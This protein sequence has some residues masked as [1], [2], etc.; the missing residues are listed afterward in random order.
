MSLKKQI[1]IATS[2][3]LMISLLLSV[4]APAVFAIQGIAQAEERIQQRWQDILGMD[5]TEDRETVSHNADITAFEMPPDTSDTEPDMFLDTEYQTTRFIIVYENNNARQRGRSRLGGRGNRRLQILNSNRADLLIYDEELDIEQVQSDLAMDGV[6]FALIQPDF[7]LYMSSLEPGIPNLGSAPD[8]TEFYKNVADAHTASQGEG[9]LIA[10][11]D[12]G[13]E[14]THTAL[15]GRLDPNAWDFVNK[16][17]SV[18]DTDWAYEQGHGTHLAGI[19]VGGNGVEGIASQ[20]TLLPLKVFQ[21]GVAYTSDIIEAI[22]Y[23]EQKGASIANCSWGSRFYNPALKEAMTGSSMLFVTAAG[24]AAMNIDR[25]PVYPAAFD[26]PNVISV[27]AIDA[28]NK[29]SRFSNFG[30]ETIDI[31]APGR[32]VYSAWTGGRFVNNSGTSQAAAIISGQAALI[33][34]QDGDLS[35][36]QLRSRIISSGD[37]ITGLQDKVKDGRRVN[38]AAALSDNPVNTTVLDIPDEP[39]PDWEP[40]EVPDEDGYEEF[41]AQDLITRRASMPTARYGLQ[42]VVLNGEIW[43]I[44]GQTGNSNNNFLNKVEIYNPK[45][46]TWR[47]GPPMTT[48]R[49]YFGAVVVDGGIYVF[50][51][52]NSTSGNALNTVEFFNPATNQWITRTAMPA[53]RDSHTATYYNG[54]IYIIGGKTGVN[55]GFQNTVFRYNVAANTWTT[56]SVAAIRTTRAGHI[57]VELEGKLYIDG[58]YN[59]SNVSRYIDTSEFIDLTKPTLISEN[60]GHNRINSIRAATVSVGNQVYVAGG[61]VL[62]TSQFR[63]SVRRFV[64]FDENSYLQTVWSMSG[65]R[66]GLGAV[67]LDGNIY[68]IGGFYDNS[69]NPYD[70]VECIE[71]GQREKSPLPIQ[72]SDCLTVELDGQL[73]LA[74]GSQDGVYQEKMYRYNT[75]DNEWSEALDVPL[76]VDSR[77]VIASAY[78]K[79]YLFGGYTTEARD[80]PSK[81]IW[82]YDPQT[83]IWTPKRE[84]PSFSESRRAIFYEGIIYLVGGTASSS[85]DIYDPLAADP[86]RGWQA[87]KPVAGGAGVYNLFNINSSLVATKGSSVLTYQPATDTWESTTGPKV[88]SG[89]N[90]SQVYGDIF[91]IEQGSV[92][93]YLYSSNTAYTY[94]SFID[95][96]IHGT[97]TVDNKI[98]I[99]A[100]DSSSASILLEYTPPVNTWNN[101]TPTLPVFS[102]FSSGAVIDGELYIAGGVNGQNPDINR[103]TLLNNLFKFNPEQGRIDTLAPMPTAV[104]MAATA[105]L[106]GEL[107]II[108]GADT[109]AASPRSTNEVQ[110]YNP[111]TKIWRTTDNY[112]R[113]HNS[114]TA[115]AFDG[116]IYVFGG[117]RYDSFDGLTS[118]SQQVYE[119]NPNA[120]RKWSSKQPM[121]TPRYGASAITIDDKIYVIGG[122]RG[123]TLLNTV[124]VYCP[125]SNTWDISKRNLPEGI[126]Y[127]SVTTD[128]KYIYLVGGLIGRSNTRRASTSVYQ[129][130]PETDVWRTLPGLELGLYAN[131]A[132]Y[133]NDWLY[134]LNGRT[135]IGTHYQ[136][137]SFTSVGQLQSD[138]THF[139]DS[140][141]NPS[142]NLSRSFTDMSLLTPG[143]SLDISRTYNSRDTRNN[144]MFGRGWTFGFQGSV[145]TVGNDTVVRLPNGGAM[146]F[147]VNADGTYTA[148]D[149]RAALEKNSDNTYML[150]TKDRYT[151]R[152]NTRG[153]LDRMTDRNGNAIT[154][155]VDNNGNVTRITDPVGRV[156]EVRYTHTT[157]NNRR[158]GTISDGIRTITY[159]Y[160]DTNRRL[161]R[162]IDSSGI[163]THYT[164]NTDGYLASVRSHAERA[165]DRFAFESFTYNI[166][167]GEALPKLETLT[168]R[169]GNVETYVYDTVQGIVTA[170]DSNERVTATWF[171]KSLYPIRVADPEGRETRTEYNLDG[172]INRWGEP[173]MVRDRNGNSTFYNRDGRGNVTRILNPDRSEKRFSYDESD[174]LIGEIDEEGKRT[175]FVYDINGNL[176]RTVRPLTSNA[177]AY[178]A[179]GGQVHQ[180]LFAVTTNA[181]KNRTNMG[182]AGN[183][184]V[185]GLLE[186]VTDPEG[187]TTTF[188]YDMH[189]NIASQ[190]NALGHTTNFVYNNVGWMMHETT[191]R[192]NRAEY[193]YDRAGRLLKTKTDDCWL[194]IYSEERFVFDANG[195]LTQKIS[196]N[197]YVDAS[198]TAQFDARHILTSGTY[199]APTHGHR[200]VYDTNDTLL[201][202]TDAEGNRTQYT[203]YDRYGN[204]LI[205]I[206]PDLTVREYKYDVMNRV[207]QVYHRDA[208]ES[209]LILLEEFNYTIKTNSQTTEAHR[210]YFDDDTSALTTTTFDWAGRPV[211]VDMPDG[212]HT[213]MVYNRNGTLRK[214]ID[215]EKRATYYDYDNLNRHIATW[216]PMEANRYQYTGTEYD[217]ADREI[218]QMQGRDI[219]TITGIPTIANIPALT[220]CVWTHITYNADN[221]VSSVTTS[222]GGRT[223]FLNYDADGNPHTIRRYSTANAFEED[224]F[225][226]NPRGRIHTKEQNVAQKDLFGHGQST[227]DTLVHLT[228]TYYYDLNGNLIWELSSN[229]RLDFY[230]YDHLNRLTRTTMPWLEG[231]TFTNE[232]TY[233]WRGQPLTQKDGRGNTSVFQYDKFGHLSRITNAEGDVHLFEHDR[234][235]RKIREVTPQ[236]FVSGGTIDNMSRIEY[237]YDLLGRLIRKIDI[238]RNPFNNNNFIEVTSAAYKYDANG[239]LIKELS[240]EAYHTAEGAT[241]SA[242]IENGLGTVYTYDW[243][244]QLLSMQT[245]AAQE[246]GY[247]DIQY[248]YDGLGRKTRETDAS[249][250]ATEFAYDDHGNLLTVK[251]FD[252]PSAGTD[253]VLTANTYDLLGRLLTATDA[254]GGTTTYTYNAF[255]QVRTVTLPGDANIPAHTTT[256]RYDNLGRLVHS[257]D[258]LGKETV[259]AYD[260]QDRVISQ[261]DRRADGTEAVTRTWR[262]DRNGSLI[263]EKDGNGTVFFHTYDRANRRRTSRYTVGG[264]IKTTVFGYDRAGN[265]LTTTDWLGNVQ[266]TEYDPLGRAIRI[267]DPYSATVPIETLRYNPDGNQVQSIYLNADGENR[268]KTFAYDS[269][270]RLLSTTTPYSAGVSITESQ[271]YDNLGNINS[272]T[273]GRG[274]T[275]SYEYN[276][277]GWLLG[278]KTAGVP[279][280]AYT[281][282]IPSKSTKPMGTTSSTGF[283]LCLTAILMTS[284][285]TPTTQTGTSSPTPAAAS[286]PPTPTTAR[287]C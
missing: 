90:T 126:G 16:D 215:A 10:L 199:N 268:T 150:T 13:I 88:F 146:S 207:T 71:S 195:R 35:A 277:F 139:G 113:R 151:Y 251:T 270:G 148:R 201:S 125:L 136:L 157:G 87:K 231:G 158:I 285:A 188:T 164:Y 38:M 22:E 229:N 234:A 233:D 204:V 82:E 9:V 98:Y 256:H 23:A 96:D 258:T 173:R 220:A 192:G 223:A 197:Q 64:G 273:D 155:A 206:M 17:N 92:L 14:T 74:G 45:T 172:G 8:W 33:L 36:S 152:F 144:T 1:K 28:T 210:V 248:Q 232:T 132:A 122:F 272:K 196:P 279:A 95:Y 118:N 259:I 183:L 238:Y 77:C 160:H 237:E 27:S 131:V 68:L 169:F 49:S 30:A 50:G 44:G 154:I 78:G 83:D 261:T 41:G 167:H 194:W 245:P 47:D 134:A 29:H 178:D 103:R 130:N 162:A 247:I 161:L 255:G 66:S 4:C 26:L 133:M 263:E 119:Y 51:G 219:L 159:E 19:M 153:H 266:R 12:S 55:T 62:N 177:P 143:F 100:G 281:A 7:P 56:N 179:D 102:S 208:I 5:L 101:I 72:V 138:I 187:N 69:N 84:M 60:L 282:V 222:G 228:T 116:K 171:D 85:V 249:G 182:A 287:V 185:R 226:Y 271:T 15:A 227:S 166:P 276:R 190:T 224:Y 128:G 67:A 241:V 76:F 104:Q 140:R 110:V 253:T 53:V 191:P 70:L 275:V 198:D 214:S 175:Y 242:K 48:R 225:T 235:G 31:A 181:Y 240:A 111:E 94:Q 205:A 21:G 24:N 108:G 129:Y 244:G 59:H 184:T 142:G 212:T 170:T 174:N 135:Y 11:L 42:T 89:R 286:P 218:R 61:T 254:K 203:S 202:E 137:T 34:A 127:S 46:D 213:E 93:R 193:F 124:E 209:P 99:L 278:I 54:N 112:P 274:V 252:F 117:R 43:A 105:V 20:A 123:S 40:G 156:F 37:R 200:F 39:M 79:L 221:T 163:I 2:Y 269:N 257:V 176:L 18:N 97:C 86:A 262:Y 52:R 81:M 186:T 6:E 236:N 141:I 147:R 260:H 25:H 149:S 57:A 189:G 145:E 211:R 284:P 180:N 3:I 216:T 165:A 283:V 80:T 58:G 267:F 230:E 32:D 73:Y 250:N 246:K 63:A 121:P 243:A 239:R 107:Y 75:I 280:A 217:R 168:D 115:A 114:M 91:E 265:L 264:V 106:N 65:G 120:V 109:T